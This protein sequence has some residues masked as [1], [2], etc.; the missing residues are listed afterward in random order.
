MVGLGLFLL[1]VSSFEKAMI[2]EFVCVEPLKKVVDELFEYLFGNWEG[3]LVFFVLRVQDI[4]HIN[5]LCWFFFLPVLHSEF[6]FNR[7]F[8]FI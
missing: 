3:G 6:A 2:C 1:R 5:D 7:A 4:G 8:E